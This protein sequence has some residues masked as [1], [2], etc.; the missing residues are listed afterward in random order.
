MI[1]DL[2]TTIDTFLTEVSG[3]SL[4]DTNKVLDFC[5]DLRQI[6]AKEREEAIQCIATP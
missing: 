1:E 4:V 5:L 3:Q 2:L 6:V